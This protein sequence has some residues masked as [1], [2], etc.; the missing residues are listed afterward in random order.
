MQRTGLADLA[1]RGVQIAPRGGHLGLQLLERLLLAVQLGLQLLAP[2]HHLQQRILQAG[3]A[4]LQGLQLVLKVGQ[5]LGVDRS[6]LQQRAVAVFALAHRVDLG[7]QPPHVSI[8]V[9]QGDSHRPQP[10]TGGVVFLLHPLARLLLGQMLGPVRQPGQL[11]IHV[12]QL[13]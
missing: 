12:R 10:V 11:G 9:F 3:L 5:L 2:L 4:T 6:G 7:F 1:A 13:Q 8:D